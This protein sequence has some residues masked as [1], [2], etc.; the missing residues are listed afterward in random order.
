M[1]ASLRVSIFVAA[2]KLALAAPPPV[3]FSLPDAAGKTHTSAELGHFQATVL[4][5]VATDCPN[6]NTYAPV[7]ARLYREYSAQ[8]VQ[9]LGVYSDPAD[10]AAAVEKHD[11]EYQIPYSALLDPN[12]SLALA[13]GADFFEA[14]VIA[15]FAG[16]I[17]V[18]KRG[19]A[20]A[21]LTEITEAIRNA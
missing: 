9:F 8:G 4:L 16:G 13:A 14:A 17:V 12:H 18:M 20:T 5:F 7:F 19:T 10:S 2:C 11:A 21:S 6:S 3:T 15:N 1:L